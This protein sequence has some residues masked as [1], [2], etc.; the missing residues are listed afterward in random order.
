MVYQVHVTM[1]LI[2]LLQDLTR[3]ISNNE[4]MVSKIEEQKYFNELF[5]S[6]DWLE[7]IL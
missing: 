2:Y 1:F 5:K 4:H 3:F 6:H 7:E